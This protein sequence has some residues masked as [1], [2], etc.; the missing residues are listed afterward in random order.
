ME[1]FN[2]IVIVLL[3][4]LQVSFFSLMKTNATW[5]LI[6]SYV[7]KTLTIFLIVCLIC[8]NLIFNYYKVNQV[9]EY[10]FFTMMLTWIGI[11]LLILGASQVVYNQS[12]I[13]TLKGSYVYLMIG[14][15]FL[16]VFFFNDEVNFRFILRSI[17]FIGSTYAVVLLIQ[18]FLE[19]SSHIFLDFGN[20]GLNPIY[21]SFGPIFHF[22]RVAGPADFISFAILLTLIKMLHDKFSI[23]DLSLVLIDYLYIVLVSGTR[24]YMIIDF[25]LIMTFILICLYQKH[26]GIVYTIIA[27]GFLLAL[28]ILPKLIQGFTGGER[29]MSFEIRTNEI[30]YY[31]DKIFYNQWF[32]IGFPDA[33]RYSQLIHGPAETHLFSTNAN[34]YLEDIGALGIISIFG[35]L[36]IIALIWFILKLV[37]LFLVSQRKGEFG[38][39]LIYLTLMLATLSLL[40]PQRIFYLFVIIYVLEYISKKTSGNNLEGIL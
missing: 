38:L 40:D 21:D 33:K 35:A 17:S 13:T 34:Y 4:L 27:G 26:A 14:L 11:Y 29:G 2:R 5:F 8:F 22:I 32:G 30:K 20:Y 15:Y 19:K 28:G 7:Y 36:G 16:L 23:F 39:I 9:R 12:F 18:A 6:N 25:I 10:P 3:L 31:F 37:T 24:M 1:K